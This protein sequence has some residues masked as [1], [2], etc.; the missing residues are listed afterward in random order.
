M[1]EEPRL[2][3]RTRPTVAR[4][5][6]A[7]GPQQV[8]L[9]GV[10][11]GTHFAHVLVA[12]DFL[13]KR[14]AM[15]FE[16]APIDGPAELLELLQDESAPLPKN[17]MPRWW[18]APHY[19][20]LLKDEEGLAWQL[21]GPGV[22]TLT[23]DGFL[24]RGGTVVARPAKEHSLAKKWADAMTAKYDALA[25]KLPVFA[26]LRNCMDLAVVAA[27]LVKEDLPGRAGCDLRSCWT[28]SGSPSPSIT[29]PRQSTRGPA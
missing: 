19:E 15:N 13:M 27:L 12:A 3:G 10:P 24:G 1:L 6:E 4:L 18:M 20:P 2:A 11:A 26:E 23:E 25:A 29:C 7:V 8:T 22:Q 17:A 14:L 9:T 28:R 5:E 16:P 21:R